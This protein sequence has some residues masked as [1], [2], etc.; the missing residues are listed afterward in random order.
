M[1]EKFK[2]IVLTPLRKASLLAL[3][4]LLLSAGNTHASGSAKEA[5]NKGMEYGKQG[6]FNEAITEFNKA[7]EIDPNS[8]N[9]YFNRGIAHKYVGDYDQ[10]IVD[11]SKVVEINPKADNAYTNRG[12]IYAEKGDYDRAIS[13]YNRA[14]EINPNPKLANAYSNRGEAYFYKKN[15]NKSWEDINKAESLGNKIDSALFEKLK[16]ASG[17]DK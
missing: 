4:A 1:L 16:K 14:I 13:D 10:A 8:Y 5:V 12:N 15:Y 6:K 17:R 11:Y 2:Y 3:I 9:A 7:I